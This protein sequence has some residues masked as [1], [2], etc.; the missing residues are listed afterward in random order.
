M[1]ICRKIKRILFLS[2]FVFLEVLL[3]FA[4]DLCKESFVKEEIN[5]DKILALALKIEQRTKEAEEM[6]DKINYIKELY[7]DFFDNSEGKVPFKSSELQ[8]LESIH[9]F[10]KFFSK[11]Y[12]TFHRI[13]NIFLDRAIGMELSEFQNLENKFQIFEE[14]FNRRS[15]DLEKHIEELSQNKV[16][17]FQNKASDSDKSLNEDRISLEDL[18]ENPDLLKAD[19]PY[20]VEF[21]NNQ[22]SAFVIFSESIVDAFLNPKDKFFQLV[23]LKK[24]LSAIKKGFINGLG[25]NG[26]KILGRTGGFRSNE[27]KYKSI[28]EIKTIGKAGNVRL[29]GFIDDQGTLHVVHYKKGSEHTVNRINNFIHT[30]I[31]KK[32]STGKTSHLGK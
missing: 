29:G 6:V 25:L 19:T 11:A 28:F 32:K 7:P 5:E 21:S 3:C 23:L 8:N 15:V 1:L 22:L 30:I 17:N 2:G 14:N 31:S 18:I 20:F 24:N 16:D 12:E 10:E 9:S 13:N 27:N 4:V 26:L